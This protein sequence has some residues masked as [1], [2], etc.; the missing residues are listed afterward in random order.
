MDLN[1]EVGRMSERIEK[2]VKDLKRT[3]K[4]IYA[5]L[6]DELK[7]YFMNLEIL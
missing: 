2:C 7:K 1:L 6:L 3:P 5:E 4:S